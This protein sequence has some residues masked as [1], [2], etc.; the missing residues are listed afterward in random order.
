MV[1][2]VAVV[3]D[4][5]VNLGVLMRKAMGYLKPRSRVAMKGAVLVS[6]RVL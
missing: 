2:K 5:A 6:F 1:L 4:G 3:A